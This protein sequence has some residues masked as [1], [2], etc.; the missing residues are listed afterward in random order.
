MGKPLQ[1]AVDGMAGTMEAA[2]HCSASVQS[3]YWRCAALWFDQLS[4]GIVVGGRPCWQSSRATSRR[5]CQR[6]AAISDERKRS[7]TI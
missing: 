4:L 3:R 2:Q 5:L 6:R 1:I 7:H